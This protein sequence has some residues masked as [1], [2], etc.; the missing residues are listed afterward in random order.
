MHRWSGRAGEISRHFR[1]PSGC[2]L[3][4]VCSCSASD[5]ALTG[6]KRSPKARDHH[7]HRSRRNQGTNSI[8]PQVQTSTSCPQLDNSFHQ[9][10]LAQRKAHRWNCSV[11]QCIC[12]LCCEFPNLAQKLRAVATKEGLS[13]C[14]H[15][16]GQEGRRTSPETRLRKCQPRGDSRH[17]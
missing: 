9:K 10:P 4:K 13:C 1:H 7:L 8:I 3:S 15:A 5:P 17:L 11:F 6:T 12:M 14:S 2:L 16:A